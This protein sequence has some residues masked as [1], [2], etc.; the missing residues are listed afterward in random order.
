MECIKVQR[1][2]TLRKTVRYCIEET[3]L[4]SRYIQRLGVLLVIDEDD[5][6]LRHVYPLLGNQVFAGPDRHPF[7]SGINNGWFE[8][9]WM[10]GVE[11][12]GKVTKYV[13]D[14]DKGMVG[15]YIE[16]DEDDVVMEIHLP[17]K[18]I[19]LSINWVPGFIPK[20]IES[21]VIATDFGADLGGFVPFMDM[22]QEF[23]D[24]AKEGDDE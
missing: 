9:K 13:T 8:S 10:A 3:E 14:V 15:A 1:T 5:Y 2:D 17:P 12:W 4:D 18:R 7:S 23:A 19:A 20:D 22:L 11:D 6:K 16:V 21:Q 24:M